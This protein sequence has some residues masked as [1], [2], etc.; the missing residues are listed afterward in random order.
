VGAIDFEDII[1][2]DRVLDRIPGGILSFSYR[3][4]SELIEIAPKLGIQLS[5]DLLDPVKAAR[6]EAQIEH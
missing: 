1:V 5:G 4:R 2:D 3:L 6:V